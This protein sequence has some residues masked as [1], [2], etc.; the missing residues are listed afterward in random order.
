MMFSLAEKSK[1]IAW[2][3]WVTIISGLGLGFFFLTRISLGISVF[4]LALVA[5]SHVLKTR[6]NATYF[7]WCDGHWI[8]VMASL[9]LAYFFRMLALDVDHR[10]FDKA[11]RL[12]FAIPIFWIIRSYG[13]SISKVLI[14]IAI[15]VL[16]AGFESLIQASSGVQRVSGAS[17]TNPIPFGNFALLFGVLSLLLIFSGKENNRFGWVKILS[18]LGFISGVYTSV[19]S[20]TRGGWVAIPL[21]MWIIWNFFGSKRKSN[22]YAVV[23]VIVVVL[24]LIAYLVPAISDRLVQGFAEAKS[25]LSRTSLWAA[26]ET[27][28]SIGIRLDMWATGIEAFRSAPLFGLGFAGFNEFLHYRIEMGL[29]HPDLEAEGFKHLHCEIITTGAKLGLLGLCALAILWVGGIRWFLRDITKNVS[30]GKIFRAMGL[31]TF[32]AMI[33]YSMTDS[34]FGMTIHPMV[35]A[36]LLGISAGGLRH[37]ELNPEL[38]TADR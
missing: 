22:T 10:L 23:V 17:I 27:S 3:D 7:S 6:K 12:L 18:I 11:V 31:I 33:A 34:M 37:A 5:A 26:G 29:S 15:S 21:F 30:S 16:M 8:I 13:I 2:K 4:V 35:Y 9:P 14:C 25:Y 38:A 20:G 28:T 1:L 32:T 36:M 24:P 19:A